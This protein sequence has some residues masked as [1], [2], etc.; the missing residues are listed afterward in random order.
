MPTIVK[1]GRAWPWLPELMMEEDSLYEDIIDSIEEGIVVFDRLGVITLFNP[2]AEKITGISKKKALSS[3]MKEVFAHN[4]HVVEQLEK[5]LATGQVFSDYDTLFVKRNGSVLPVSLTTSPVLNRN[6]ETKGI[7]LLVRDISRIK[8][9]EEDVRR[10]DSLASVGILAA[11]L[12][13]EIKNP[14]GGIKGSA[15]LLQMEIDAHEELKSYTEV[16]IKESERVSSLLEDLLDFSNPKKLNLGKINI[17][18]ILDAVI[19]L[20]SRSEEGKK[21]YFTAEYDPSIPPI[22]GDS[23]RLSQV[24]INIIKNGCEAMDGAGKLKISTRVVSDFMIHE[25]EGNVSKMISIDV[26]DSGKGMSP[27]DVKQLFTP[28]FTRKRSGAGLGLSVSHRI[29]KE[30]RGSIKVKSE[31]GKGSIFSVLLP[32]R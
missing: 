28:F 16:I 10:S 27:E 25:R 18:E 7:T 8:S 3:G 9:L 20:I 6:G 21:V 22:P 17:Y 19:A 26:E 29:I 12:A 30:H 1:K 32:L 15:Q 2:L 31:E 4:L 14:L 11:G 23:E 13:H 5:T 24:F